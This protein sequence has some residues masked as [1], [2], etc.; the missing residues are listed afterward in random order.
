MFDNLVLLLSAARINFKLSAFGDVLLPATSSHVV[1]VFIKRQPFYFHL[2]FPF[3]S[4][5]TG[6]N[7]DTLLLP[8][9]L[10]FASVGG[11][12]FGNEPSTFGALLGFFR[13]GGEESGGTNAAAGRQACLVHNQRTNFPA[14]FTIGI[15]SGFHVTEY[16]EK[17]R[18]EV[19]V[20]F[21]P[22]FTNDL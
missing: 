3:G 18:T 13:F 10:P 9:G 1:F 6:N 21:A 12:A 8:L 4:Y 15:S 5:L 7:S 2:T 14:L 17:T 16:S 11:S 19:V 20:F 22:Q